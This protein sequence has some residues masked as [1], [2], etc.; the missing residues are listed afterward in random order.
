M[1]QFDV[2]RNPAPKRFPL[3]LDVQADLLGRL[4]SR[5]VIPMI[6][7]AR[8]GARPITRLHPVVRFESADYVLVAHE[9]AAVPSAILKT[10]IGSLAAQRPALIDALD[11]LFTGA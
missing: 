2:F 11:L 4:E 5:V 10:R 8:Y 1:A 9:L 3:L 7:L 6:T